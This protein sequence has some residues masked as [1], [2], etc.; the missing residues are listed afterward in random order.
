M[1]QTKTYD[2][3][4][5]KQQILKFQANIYPNSNF[6][7]N[8]VETFDKYVHD[9]SMQGST[10]AQSYACFTENS[11]LAATVDVFLCWLM[12]M[13]RCKIFAYVR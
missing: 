3:K 9:D 11:T 10:S 4:R 7:K 12:N 2:A 13:C 1:Q 6:I 8:Q 5:H